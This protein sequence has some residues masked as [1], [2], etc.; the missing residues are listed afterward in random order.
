MVKIVKYQNKNDE[1]RYKFRLYAGVDDA[2]GKQ[3]YIKRTNFTTEKDAL[4]T[5]EK[6]Q[7]ELKTGQYYKNVADRMQFKEVYLL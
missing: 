5:L 6:I 4:E 3:R 1:T 7:Y 2:T